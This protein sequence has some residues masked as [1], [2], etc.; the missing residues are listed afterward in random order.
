MKEIVKLIKKKDLEEVI[1][2]SLKLHSFYPKRYANG[3]DILAT[4]LSFF[5]LEN[6]KVEE[7]LD[8]DWIHRFTFFVDYFDLKLSAYF[9]S[10]NEAINIKKYIQLEKKFTSKD[11][12]KHIE[13][14]IEEYNK[15]QDYVTFVW[16]DEE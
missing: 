9:C 4:E 5:R 10:E 6:E 1:D 16:G 7:A 8:T 11:I 14:I 12:A 3:I 15:E 2:L 13:Q